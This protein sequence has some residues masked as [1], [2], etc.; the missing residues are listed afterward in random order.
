VLPADQPDTIIFYFVIRAA[1]SSLIFRFIVPTLHFHFT[2][3][4]PFVIDSISAHEY[5]ESNAKFAMSVEPNNPDL[6]A[7]VAKYKDLRANGKP[8]VPS[9]LVDEKKANPF[10]RCDTSAE[11]RS[12]VG[13]VDGDTEEQAFGKVR[14]AKDNF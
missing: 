7:Q 10:L 2:I 1:F 4:L 12:N 14:K 5:T 8:T 11:I 9:L 3:I 13:V 6:Q